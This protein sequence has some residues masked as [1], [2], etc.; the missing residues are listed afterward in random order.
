MALIG[1]PWVT[2]AIE[3]P[4]LSLAAWRRAA[5]AP[6]A[7]GGKI[8]AGREVHGGRA[9]HPPF[10]ELRSF[11]CDLVE[12]PALK[13]A[14]V[15]LGQTFDDLERSPGTGRDGSRCVDCALAGAGVHRAEVFR[16]EPPPQG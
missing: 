16:R 3:P 9:L 10:V 5:V 7:K 1:P 4:G 12:A 15:N 11:K 6:Y 13:I 2:M 8:L 14:K